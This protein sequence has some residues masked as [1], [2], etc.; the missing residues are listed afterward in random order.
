MRGAYGVIVPNV[1]SAGEAQRAVDSVKYPPYG[2]EE[3]DFTAP[4]ATAG[5]LRLTKSGWPKKVWSSFKL[6]I[7]MP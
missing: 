1:N 2:K 4:N 5:N 7:S 6:N 3:S